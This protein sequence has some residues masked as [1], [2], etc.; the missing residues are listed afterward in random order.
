MF[1]TVILN[2]GFVLRV[3][4]YRWPLIFIVKFEMRLM[5][6]PP[7]YEALFRRYVNP[8]MTR[9]CI[10]YPCFRFKNM[11]T[12]TVCNWFSFGI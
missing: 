11:I 12:I 5:V 8:G 10:V 1:A 4:W 3:F 6:R 7:K 9:V 2:F